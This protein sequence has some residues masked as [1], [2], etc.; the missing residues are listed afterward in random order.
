MS[1]TK[2]KPTIKKA[3][4]IPDN[5]SD[6]KKGRDIK[7][8]ATTRMEI[9]LF[10]PQDIHTLDDFKELEKKAK[11]SKLAG[12]KNKYAPNELHKFTLG[13]KKLKEYLQAGNM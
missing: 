9:E 3:N 8:S 1:L 5:G 10:P 13:S 4:D 11:I 7:I 2:K 6:K 12:I